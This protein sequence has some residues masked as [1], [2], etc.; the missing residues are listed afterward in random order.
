MVSFI[1]QAIIDKIVA[2]DDEQVLECIKEDID[3][4]TVDKKA[5]EVLE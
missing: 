2:T 5:R 3:Y 4:L 1:K